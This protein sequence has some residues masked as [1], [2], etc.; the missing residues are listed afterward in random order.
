MEITLAQNKAFNVLVYYAER[1]QPLNLTK[2]IKLLYIA[3]EKAMRQSGVPITWLNYKAWKL[4]P[5]QEDIYFKIK[6][7]N[8]YSKS[9]VDG[10]LEVVS[11]PTVLPDG[12]VLKP[13]KPFDDSQFSDYEIDVL[14]EVLKQYGKYTSEQLVEIL[15]REG[16]LWHKVVKEHHLEKQ[17]ELKNNRSDYVIELTDLLDTDFKK[18][19]FEVA[20]RSYL[21]QANLI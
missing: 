15:H 7:A 14:D 1:I 17:F 13:R 12:I 2:A 11:A 21:M 18:S 9:G 4:G 8:D 16:S 10:S 19:A 5:V 3:D 20:Y 6:Q